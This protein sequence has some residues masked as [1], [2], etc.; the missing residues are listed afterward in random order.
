MKR[1][2]SLHAADARRLLRQRSGRA[3]VA[4]AGRG[5]AA[6]SASL[7]ALG[8]RDAPVLIP[9]NTC[10]IVLWAVLD[11]GNRPV[12]V[13]IDPA[14]GSMTPE[15]L[16][17]TGIAQPGAIVPA[18][19]Y[20]LPA[21]LDALAAWAQSYGAAV[22]ED[23]ALTLDLPPSRYADV[24]ITSFGRGKPTDM[25]NGGAA[26]TD[27][28]HLATEI[29]QALADLPL[30]NQA[31]RRLNRQWLDLYWALHQ[32]EA[33]NPRLAA[34]YPAL[35]DIYEPILRYRLPEA[36]WRDFPAALAAHDAETDH[37][38]TLARL[39]DE[40]LRD[41][42]VRTLPRAADAVL[43][44]YPLRA[45]A[46]RRDTLLQTLWEAGVLDA[47]RWYP[48]LQPMQT[49]LAPD[50]PRTT[51]PNADRFAAE[52]VNLPLSAETPL[53]E[54]ERIAG[55]VRQLFEAT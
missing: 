28:E 7:R 38:R 31:L 37:R 48:S 18:H 8:L 39:Y 13:D 45:P 42:P 49:A 2:G 5:A 26:L 43:W 36:A 55:V 12:L 54:A 34:L 35:F 29:T 22:I 51:T 10:Y 46:D 11:S 16:A 6:L 53:D 17:Q 15:T 32:H 27:D 19:M 30:W 1:P 40:R 24:T 50:A 3:H 41:L 44:R 14:T 23:A 52:I 4:L 33:D 47:T 25:D 21:S 9:A 20:G